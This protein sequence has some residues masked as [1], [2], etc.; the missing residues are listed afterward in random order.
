M[1]Y[2]TT[3]LMSTMKYFTTNLLPL[4]RPRPGRHGFLTVP[5]PRRKAAKPHKFLKPNAL[6]NALTRKTLLVIL[7]VCP[8][9]NG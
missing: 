8:K 4:F 9:I 2:F 1:V 6:K 7:L 3:M 5:E